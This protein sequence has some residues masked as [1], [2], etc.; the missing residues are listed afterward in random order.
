MDGL[1]SWTQARLVA[2]AAGKPLPFATARLDES[3]GSLL[4]DALLAISDEPSADVAEFDGYALCAAGPWTTIDL[5][6]D[7]ALP[8]HYA[9]KLRAFEPIPPHT[10]A[11][12]P[13]SQ[14]QL[15]EI[16]PSEHQLIAFDSLN[17]TPD[18]NAAPNLAPESFARRQLHRPVVSLSPPTH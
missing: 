17:G 8:Q 13:T 11:V 6:P 4:G 18:E 15:R 2:H 10:D 9:T 5:A 1:L 3:H 7:V 12:L 16:Q 14:G